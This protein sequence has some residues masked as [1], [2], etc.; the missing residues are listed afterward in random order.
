MPGQRS[1]TA[2]RDLAVHG[3]WVGD[4]PQAGA[5]DTGP[6]GEPEGPT[7]FRPVALD[8]EEAALH[9]QGLAGQSRTRGVVVEPWTPV[10]PLGR[11][12]GSCEGFEAPFQKGEYLIVAAPAPASTLADP[13]LPQYAGQVSGPGHHVADPESNHGV[14][15]RIGDSIC[16]EGQRKDQ[17]AAPNDRVVE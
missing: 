5:E 17:P 13:P 10:V 14:S 6:T 7:V 12:S 9:F 11:V 3:L 4:A 16:I 15:Q 1:W 8:P 2:T